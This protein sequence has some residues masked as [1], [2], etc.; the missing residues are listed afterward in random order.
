[1]PSVKGGRVALRLG[2]RAKIVEMH[3]EDSVDRY[4]NPGS[5][6]VTHGRM[7]LLK[8]NSLLGQPRRLGINPNRRSLIRNT[9]SLPDTDMRT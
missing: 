7:L 3:G 1:M 6:E 2:D 9:V 5:G 8:F 4:T